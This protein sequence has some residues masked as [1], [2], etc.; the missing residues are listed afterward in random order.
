[1]FIGAPAHRQTASEGE[2]T[3]IRNIYRT[4]NSRRR[5][6]Y[7]ICF[8]EFRSPNSLFNCK[9]EDLCSAKSDVIDSDSP[10]YVDATHHSTFA[11]PGES[12][13]PFEAD[14]SDISQDDE[15]YL[16][17]SLLPSSHVFSEIGDVDYPDRPTNSC[18]YGLSGE[19]HAS[20]YWPYYWDINLKM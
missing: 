9:Q 8:K 15:D 3:G 18:Y 16:N 4:Q 10:Q 19:D 20:L 12:S 7:W 2:Q 17:K 11:E 5:T 14:H 6:H 1:M 13:Y